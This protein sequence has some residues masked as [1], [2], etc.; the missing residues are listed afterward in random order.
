MYI[1][2]CYFT[3][4]V[5]YATTIREYMYVYIY[6]YNVNLMHIYIYIHQIYIVTFSDQAVGMSIV[7]H[8]PNYYSMCIQTY[9]HSLCLST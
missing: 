5:A 9:S 6:T 8:W 4:I 1:Y 2:V 7:E 3:T